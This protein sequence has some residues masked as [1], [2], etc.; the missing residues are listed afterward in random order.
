[1]IKM[2]YGVSIVALIWAGLLFGLCGLQWLRDVPLDERDPGIPISERLRT[3]QNLNG[4]DNAASTPLVEQAQAFALYLNPPKPPS[5]TETP[6]PAIAVPSVPRPPSPAPQ[7][8]LLAISHYRSNPE[9]SLAMIWDA[10]KGGTWMRKGDR[11]GHFVVERIEKDAI[12]YRDGDQ[13]R[14]MAMTIKEPVQLARLKSKRAASNQNV[15]ANEILV[16]ASQ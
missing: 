1:M 6:A 8:K 5:Q 13:L 7:F 3:R 2:L 15:A 14:Q 10:S 16:S 4:D 12:F 11:L 9:M